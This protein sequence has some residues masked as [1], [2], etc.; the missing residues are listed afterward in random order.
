M[1]VRY[2][3]DTSPDRRFSCQFILF[4]LTLLITL[5][6][7]SVLN[8]SSAIET[9]APIVYDK[10]LTIETVYKGLKFPTNMA[11]L[12]PNDI[13]VL[14]KNEG[15]VQRITNGTILSEPLLHVKVSAT[16]ERGMLGIAIGNNK[17]EA[18]YPIVFLYY[19]KP[20]KGPNGEEYL[21]SN[22]VYRFELINDK[23]VNRKTLFHLPTLYYPIHNGGILLMG[24]DN[25]LY[26]MVG[27]GQGDVPTEPYITKLKTQNY[28]SGLDPDG[29]GGI[30]RITQNGYPINEEGILGD[31]IPLSLYYA[32]GIRNS[33]GMDFDPV[34]G[35][36]W[37]TENGG[38]NGDEINLVSPGF[39]SGWQKVMGLSSLLKNFSKSELEAFDGK[40]HYSDP[41]F[42][43]NRTA[44]LTALKFLNSDK[45]GKQYENDMFVGDFNN[46]FLYHFDLDAKRKSLSL[47]GK[48][49]DKIADENGELKDI[50][51][52]TGFAGITDI[53]VG[54][55]GYLYI[56]S[57]E[58]GGSNCSKQ[59]VQDCVKYE[60]GIVG[61]IYRI[62]PK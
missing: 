58:E 48:L 19:T 44:G 54:P 6:A 39:N 16:G 46:G 47:T 62:V 40:G 33:Y 52:G 23:L 9:D 14:E 8:Y 24:P 57:V 56:L 7:A 22:S 17:S 20:E 55:D 50:I 12:A 49:E 34:T 45:L 4:C 61:T 15:N 42:T 26:L 31:S 28:R 38:R 51:F 11:F 13:L 60:T 27:S 29:R 1:T 35:K 53:K 18:E 25:N 5:Y 43:W 59:K 37:D 32:Y 30:L 10:N 21:G 36:L 2:C 3:R 41:E